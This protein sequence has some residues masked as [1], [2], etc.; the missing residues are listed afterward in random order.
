MSRLLLLFVVT[1]DYSMTWVL[2]CSRPAWNYTAQTYSNQTEDVFLTCTCTVSQLF[3]PRWLSFKEKN[4][5]L[6]RVLLLLCDSPTQIQHKPQN[7]HK[8]C[9]PFDRYSFTLLCCLPSLLYLFTPYKCK[10]SAVCQVC[11]GDCEERCFP[12]CVYYIVL[13]PSLDLV[14]AGWR[15]LLTSSSSSSSSLHLCERIWQGY[16]NPDRSRHRDIR[17]IS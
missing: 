6:L 3:L 5:R 14:Y 9:F 13:H 12:L 16:L 8:D 1:V 11:L 2:S 15:C 10:S 4:L 17:I 7:I